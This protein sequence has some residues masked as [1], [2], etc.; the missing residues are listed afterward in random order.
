MGHPGWRERMRTERKQKENLTGSMQNLLL[1]I[2]T[3]SNMVS[4]MRRLS[5]DLDGLL[6][7]Q[8]DPDQI[9]TLLSQK[10]SKVDT[11]KE[12][13]K[14]IRIMLRVD[15][16]GAVGISL[17]ESHKTRFVHLMADFRELLEEES[18]LQE[19]MCERGFPITRRVG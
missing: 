18:R 15:E 17:P 16:D 11:L 8:G 14:E 13:A 1:A 4:E 2:E 6:R 19:L 12:L 9:I 5:R 3:M 7:E 10:K